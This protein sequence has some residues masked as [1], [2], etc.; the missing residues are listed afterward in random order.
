MSRPDP[1]RFG[2]PIRH[3][4]LVARLART[5][6]DLQACLGLRALAFRGDPRA[7]DDDRFDPDCLHLMVAGPGNAVLATLRAYPHI[8]GRIVGYGAQFYDLTALEAEPGTALELGRL[9]LHPG[10]PDPDLIRLIWAGVSRL[11]D[12]WHAARLIG[13]TSFPGTDPDL[14]APALGLLARRHI[15]PNQLRPFKRALQIRLLGDW[16]DDAHPDGAALLPP[17]LRSYLAL[18]GWVSDHLVIDADLN[19]CHVFTCL[20]IAAMPAGRKRILRR[21]AGQGPE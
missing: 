7:R 17:L 15:G 6:D 12:E 20:E 10:H 16:A 11:V 19:T 9:C 8:P 5:P 13:C 4:S 3:G 14:M 21:L 1:A 2:P 18:G